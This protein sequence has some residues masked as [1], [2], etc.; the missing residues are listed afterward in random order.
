MM[1]RRWLDSEPCVNYKCP[2]N[3]FWE[4]LK[5]N[6]EKIQMTD[7]ALGI[8]N[9]CCLVYEP[10]APEQIGTVWRLAE[11][12][13]NQCDSMGRKKLKKRHPRNIISPN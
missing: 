4:D 7:K 10:W 6:R 1:C 9:C 12:R 13:I 2:H 11:E 5:L 3:L 8:R